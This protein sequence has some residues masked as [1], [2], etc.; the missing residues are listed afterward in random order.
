METTFRVDRRLM[1]ATIGQTKKTGD[2]FE[3]T[4]R[5]DLRFAPLC[6]DRGRLQW[7]RR[8]MGHAGRDQPVGGGAR[9]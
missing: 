1:D 4:P 8:A 3:V 2:R 6:L 7:L 9:S 5:R